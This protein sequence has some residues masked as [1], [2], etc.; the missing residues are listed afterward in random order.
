MTDQAVN[1]VRQQQSLTPEKPFFVY[2][3]PGAT[4]APHHVPKE[5]AD[6]YKGKFD[7]GWDRYR[8]ETLARQKQ[9]GVVPEDTR[10]APKPEAIRDWDKLTADER[11]VFAR[12]MEVFAGY[13]E[14]VDHEVGR[15]VSAIEGMGKM[16]NTLFI[17]IAG[18]N[19][20]SPEGGLVGLNNEAGFFNGIPEALGRRVGHLQQLG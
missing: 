2:Y 4:H 9:L 19:G 15:L 10:L 17:Y 3:A 13:G 14:M 12:Q 16:D 5:W 1:W 8:E 6:R 18:D 11:R 20:A 7:G